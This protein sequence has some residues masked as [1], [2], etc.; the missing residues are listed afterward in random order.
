MSNMRANHAATTH[1][2]KLDTRAT[3]A[4][5]SYGVSCHG[6]TKA[7]ITKATLLTQRA[8]HGLRQTHIGS[9][10]VPVEGLQKGVPNHQRRQS[11]TRG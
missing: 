2:L 1:A 11:Q 3:G 10:S 6:N 7:I 9:N 5:F 8:S 4:Q